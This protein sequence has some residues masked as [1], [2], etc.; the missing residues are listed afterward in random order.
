MWIMDSDGI[1]PDKSIRV[2]CTSNEEPSSIIPWTWSTIFV[3][4]ITSSCIFVAY[5]RTTFRR[6]GLIP[7]DRPDTYPPPSTLIETARRGL[8][9]RLMPR[10]FH[11]QVD[12]LPKAY[13]SSTIRSF[14]DS[15]TFSFT[16]A[17]DSPIR[18]TRLRSLQGHY[19]ALSAATQIFWQYGRF[20]AALS[21]LH[22]LTCV[23]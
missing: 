22:A 23:L 7:H 14:A 21:V 4:Y 11:Q 16:W 12:S 1:F 9:T 2:F 13:H 20:C 8:L 10:H 6:I 15:D 17:P 19:L 5:P 18:R 3:N